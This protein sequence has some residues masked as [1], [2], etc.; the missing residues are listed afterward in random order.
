[1]KLKNGILSMSAICTAMFS[2]N[3]SA[4]FVA[5]LPSAGAIDQIKTEG[6]TYISG[7][8]GGEEIVDKGACLTRDE[9]LL[10][11]Y[12]DEDVTNV[13]TSCI[14]D[15]SYLF[16][17]ELSDF[18][19]NIS[20][21]DTSNGKNFAG[22]FSSTRLFNHDIGNWN[23]SNGENFTNMFSGALAFNQNLNNWNTSS[24]KSSDYFNYNS[25]LSDTN[26][27]LGFQ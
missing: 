7:S 20:N 22:M 25:A 27:P 23:T 5:I 13:N 6:Y 9:L 10:M 14:T 18:N 26:I 2:V 17:G 12:N 21:W 1:M 16:E 8:N 4:A 11:L 15:F 24:S 19:Q 3:A